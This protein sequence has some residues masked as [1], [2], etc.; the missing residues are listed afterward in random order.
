MLVLYVESRYNQTRRSGQF[1]I[2]LS[3]GRYRKNCRVGDRRKSHRLAIR[4]L[5]QRE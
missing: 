4:E 3:L 1:D 2:L 5:H